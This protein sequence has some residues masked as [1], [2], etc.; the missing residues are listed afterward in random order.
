MNDR[1]ALVSH[2]SALVSHLS[3]TRL[4]SSALVS[5]SSALASRSS[6]LVSDLSL[7]RLYSSELV[8]HSSSLA[9]PLVCNISNNRKRVRF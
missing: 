8:S 4:Y 9:L 7:T 1:I 5:H 6:A 3:L 2:S